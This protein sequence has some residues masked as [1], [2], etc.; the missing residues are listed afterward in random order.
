MKNKKL[1]NLR[2]QNIMFI[3]NIITLPII[4]YSL[5]RIEHEGL[6]VF[7]LRGLKHHMY[8]IYTKEGDNRII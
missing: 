5:F 7:R 2:L 4:A 8:R 3:V 6:Y 1:Q